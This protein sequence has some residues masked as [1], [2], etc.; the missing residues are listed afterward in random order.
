ML[1]VLLGSTLLG[2]AASSTAA[3]WLPHRFPD[4]RLTL[5]TGPTA[6]LLGGL[7]T[8]VVLGPGHLAVVCA[9]ALTVSA[10]LLSLLIRRGPRTAPQ[11]GTA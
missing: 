2:L 11:A 5:A 10:A 4:R 8:R 1:W 7:V 3:R 6:A 9:V